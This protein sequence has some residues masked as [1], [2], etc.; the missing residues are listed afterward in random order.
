MK[1]GLI[2]VGVL[3]CA[4]CMILSACN[5]KIDYKPLYSDDG[6]YLEENFIYNA[7]LEKEK[8]LTLLRDGKTDY[9]IVYAE[10]ADQNVLWAVEDLRS[11]FVDR[12]GGIA[13]CTDDKVPCEKEIVIGKT[14]RS[15]QPKETLSKN[16]GY[17]IANE[18][19]A[20]Y[21]YAESTYGITNGV[22]GFMEDY[23]GCMFFSLDETYIPSVRTL[24]LEPM[25]DMQ[26]PAFDRRHIGEVDVWYNSLFEQRL[27]ARTE[28][29]FDPNGC[30]Q[31]LN[32]IDDA[33][34]AAHP[35]YYAY[36][37]GKRRT[38]DYMT[39][40][41]QLCFSNSEVV[42]LLEQAVLQEEADKPEGKEV[43][44]DISQQ[45]SMNYCHCDTC[46]QMAEDAG[47]NPAA[48]IYNCVN[49]IAKRNPD[50]KLS[51]LAYHYG[52]FPPENI[53]F[54][55]NVM[56][57]W[58]IMSSFGR[59]DYSGPLEEGRSEIAAT[60]YNEILGWAEL[61]DTIFVWDYTTN[62]FY[63]LL[64]FPC[65]N[66]MGE[67]MRLLRDCNVKG[68]LSLCSYNARGWAD[69]L[70]A[71]LASHLLWNPDI[72]YKQ[73][74]AKFVTLYLGKDAAP[75]ILNIYQ[76][77]QDTVSSPLCVYDFPFIHQNDFLSEENVEYYFAE[78][79]Q[80]FAKTTDETYLKRLRFEKACILYSA[81]RL[82]YGDETTVAEYKQEFVDI[83]TEWDITRFNEI[84]T[85]TLDTIVGR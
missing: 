35:E 25:Y 47:G 19:E 53:T 30:H 13:V 29:S 9:K 66:A 24:I 79:E 7:A 44:W 58:C 43:W 2:F 16:S 59:N 26:T 62:F 57:K 69:R 6:L 23:L 83:C 56:I 17:V 60:Q 78:L 12:C 82:G 46:M 42:D 22:Y 45:D 15:F 32:R 77:M 63:Y 31:S 36:I 28:E 50:I 41:P 76:R 40:G 34:L 20:I 61:T 10:T 64:P 84:G 85:E 38:G 33:I 55:K 81:I 1:K 67:N 8:G 68:V 74:I 3:L 80:A 54:E 52:S 70:K 48:A 4:F 37:G 65:F 51:V 72:D 39:Q 73:F 49:T 75:H 21:I 14:N 18:K 71:N 27:R 5:D 11:Y